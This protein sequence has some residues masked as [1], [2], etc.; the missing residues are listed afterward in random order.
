MK[1]MWNLLKKIHP[2]EDFEHE[3]YW[4]GKETYKWMYRSG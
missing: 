1:N 4:I 3:G 2:M